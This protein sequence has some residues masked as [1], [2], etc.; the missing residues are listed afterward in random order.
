MIGHVA[1]TSSNIKS[2][3]YA[4]DEE[5]LEVIFNNGAIY[6]YEGVPEGEYFD[7]L[8]ADSVG[9]H[10]N[11]SIKTAGYPFKKLG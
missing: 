11:K 1:V 5:I 10:F 7:L 4:K 8:Q 9:R 3:G 2:I 6:Q